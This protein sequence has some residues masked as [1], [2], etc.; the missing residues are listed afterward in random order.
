MGD[1]CRLIWFVVAGLFRS[2]AALQVEVLV[3]D[4]IGQVRLLDAVEMRPIASL[5]TFG[6]LEN[7]IG[8]QQRADAIDQ[9]HDTIIHLH[10][11]GWRKLMPRPFH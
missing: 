4:C 6:F 10:R 2:R 7:L 3:Q 5:A 1:V 9:Q 11:H 8:A